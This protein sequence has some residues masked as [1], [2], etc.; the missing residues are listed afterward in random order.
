MCDAIKKFLKKFDFSIILL[1]LN[2]NLKKD[3][4][5]AILDVYYLFILSYH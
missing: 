5:I 3:I 4:Q 2:T 1:L